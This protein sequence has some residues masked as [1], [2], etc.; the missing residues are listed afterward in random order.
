[1]AKGKK[2]STLWRQVTKRGSFNVRFCKAALFCNAHVFKL[3][4]EEEEELRRREQV[5][6]RRLEDSKDKELSSR[7]EAIRGRLK[8]LEK[9]KR[10]LETDFSKYI[11]VTGITNVMVKT[12][13]MDAPTQ[14]LVWV[15]RNGYW[16]RI[17][18]P[19]A[20]L[21][22]ALNRYRQEVYQEFSHFGSFVEQVVDS[23]VNHIALEVFKAAAP[24]AFSY[25]PFRPDR[26]REKECYPVFCKTR[27][28]YV[29]RDRVEERPARKTEFN[30]VGLPWDPRP[31][32]YKNFQKWLDSLFDKDTQKTIWQVLAWIVSPVSY[33]PH[34]LFIY[35]DGGTGKSTFLKIIR[36]IVGSQNTSAVP[37]ANLNPNSLIRLTE[38]L[39][40]LPSEGS[41]TTLPENL[42][43]AVSDQ[44]PVEVRPLYHNYYTA[45]PVA[46]LVQAWNKLPPILDMSQGIWRRLIVIPFEKKIKSPDPFILNKI[47][48]EI[49]GILHRVIYEEL[50]RLLRS[51]G[52]I[53]MSETVKRAT[54]GYKEENSAVMLFFQELREDPETTLQEYAQGV[55]WEHEGIRGLLITRED[56]Y[57]A[58]HEW[59]SSSGLRPL[60]KRNFFDVLRTFTDEI[61]HREV[62]PRSFKGRPRSYFFP[63]L[64]PNTEPGPGGP[65]GPHFS[66]KLSR[67]TSSERDNP[68]FFSNP[69]DHLDHW[70]HHHISSPDSRSFDGNNNTGGGLQSNPRRETRELYK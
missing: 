17:E 64:V 31:V 42:I 11:A 67:Y 33:W 57:Q 19:V 69:H 43:K 8:K 65:G 5:L 26:Y 2:T 15:W 41:S 53:Y 30:F 59:A 49:P 35:G 66:Q 7:L 25:V 54:A 70:D 12:P 55:R 44:E 1:M 37:L 58:F 51:H 32:P 4:Q 62:R 47:R 45:T 63:G 27:H 21:Q 22:R 56:L 16:R 36:L 50:P 61:P 34:V 9:E 40:N 52:R 48:S 18:D 28:F 13:N 20:V 60:S 24:G 46:K 23:N 14:A 29:Y 38:V 39:V 6:L 10:E 68:R 3:I